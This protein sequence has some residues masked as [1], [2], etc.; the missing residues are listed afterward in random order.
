[1]YA[2]TCSGNVL[3][4]IL[5][6]IPGSSG[7]LMVSWCYWV[8]HKPFLPRRRECFSVGF[9]WG[10]RG[11]GF[12]WGTGSFRLRWS[13]AR[14]GRGRSYAGSSPSRMALRCPGGGNVNLRLEPSLHFGEE[15][16]E[17]AAQ[18]DGGRWL[19]GRTGRRKQ[20]SRGGATGERGRSC[21]WEGGVRVRGGG[22]SVSGVERSTSGKQKRK[23]TEVIMVA[24]GLRWEMWGWRLFT[25]HLSIVIFLWET[26]EKATDAKCRRKHRIST[27][28]AADELSVAA[29]PAAE[30]R[31]A[32]EVVALPLGGFSVW[33]RLCDRP[34]WSFHPISFKASPHLSKRLQ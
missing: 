13:G 18:R 33:G 20:E 5:Q 6:Y 30:L 29:A 8:S 2:G 3:L 21:Q 22:Q 17:W 23:W 16:G 4:M 31:T 34:N 9:F 19:A 11:F 24:G 10:G 28:R 7:C 1:M 15:E 26:N 14:G 32:L 12:I 25:K 27:G